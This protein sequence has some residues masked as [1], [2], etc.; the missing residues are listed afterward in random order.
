MSADGQCL[1][2]WSS[3]SQV[4]ESVFDQIWRSLSDAQEVGNDLSW[5]LEVWPED[6]DFWGPQMPAPIS[7]YLM[8]SAY[9]AE[10]KS[11]SLTRS[12]S[13]QG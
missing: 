1:G 9:S 5:A 7:D 4:A 12:T 11:V 13:T 8:S 3:S 2:H 10:R 6:W